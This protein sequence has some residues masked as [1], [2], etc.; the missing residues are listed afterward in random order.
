MPTSG[1]SNTQISEI[2][3]FLEACAIALEA[4]ARDSC[5]TPMAALK[6]ELTGIETALAGAHFEGFG[7]DVLSSPL[8]KA[9]LAGFHPTAKHNVAKAV[10]PSS[11]MMRTT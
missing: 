3:S 8:K 9:P 4:E 1:Y 2:A 11:E 6:D 10:S 5:R 7:E